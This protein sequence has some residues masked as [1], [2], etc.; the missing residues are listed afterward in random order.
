MYDKIY[1]RPLMPLLISMISG[2]GFGL[3]LPGFGLYVYPAVFICPVL[4]LCMIKRK[5][6]GLLS[7]IFLFAALGYLLI[8]PWAFPKFTPDH[9]INFTDTSP[10]KI[11]GTIENNPLKF[12]K[13][14]TK[15]ILKAET[16]EKKDKYLQVVGKIRVTLL[17]KDP[18]LAIGDR[19]SFVGII[20]SIRNFNNP[21]GFNYERYMAFSGVWGTAFVLKEKLSILD[22]SVRPRF[23]VH[24]GDFRKKISFLI[25]KNGDIEQQ[26][27][28]KGLI[29]GE[30]NSISPQLREAFNR[31]G[32]G[33]LLAISGLHIGIVATVSFILF[34]R[35]LSHIKIFLWNAWIRKGAALL[36]LGPV[37]FYGSLT[38]MSPSTQRAVL[39][40]SVFLLTFLIEREQDTV[41]TLS[42]AAIFILIIHPPYLFSISFQLSF[43]AVLAIIYGLSKIR[44]IQAKTAIHTR[45]S[46]MRKRVILFFFVSL[47]A[48]LGTAP[49]VMLYFNQISLIGIFTNFIFVPLIGFIVVPLGLLSVFLCP[50]SYQAASLV[51]QADAALLSKAVEMIIFFSKLP[52]AA[53]KTV[54]PTYFEISC[55]YLFAWGI[56]NLKEKKLREKGTRTQA[57]QGKTTETVSDDNI[58]MNALGRLNL[59]KRF[60]RPVFSKANLAK[61]IIVIALAA[62]VMD[63]CYWL[64]NRFWHNDLRVTIIDVKQGSSSLLELP[65]GFC[66]LIDGGGFYDNSVFDVGAGVIAPFLWS[67]KIK[68]IDLLVLS[69]PESDHLNG[70]IYIAENFNV[71]KV[72]TNSQAVNTKGYKEFIRV[73]EKKKI[74]APDF[75]EISRVQTLN[76]VQINILYPPVDFIEKIEHQKWRSLNNNSIVLKVVFKSVSFLFPGDI[77]K[78]AEKELVGIAGDDLRSTVL[79]APHHGSKTSSSELFLDK[80]NPEYVIISSGWKNR[81]KFPNLSVIK[82]YRERKY[83]IFRVD[84]NGAVMLSTDGRFLKIEP[85][86]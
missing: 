1:A 28:L 20:K 13:N 77:L 73:I 16:L 40:V 81:F 82:R 50:I 32:I 79:I 33:H 72:L 64:Y 58:Y 9:I 11:T 8:H 5:R 46:R 67:K 76:S 43:S 18:K 53:L 4:M 84:E 3:W 59:W 14:R 54:T 42:A 36:S 19:I 30:R 52:F 66:I 49:L 70:L 48:M 61:I 2:L 6:Y 12:N 29:L 37:F 44:N 31:A 78:H 27:L 7:P 17:G 24:W 38:E 69:H 45:F 63:T 21:K 51:M 25:E 86:I 83:K 34:S 41:N 39:M 55:F 62:A 15:F 22:K 74:F 65:G 60:N 80:V 26:G 68:T 85:T 23:F 47:F 75:K 10:W 35:F 57:G 56:L 71:K